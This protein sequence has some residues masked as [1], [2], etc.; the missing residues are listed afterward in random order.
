MSVSMRLSRGGSKKRP[1]YKI[2]VSNSRAPRDG[3]YLE[4]VGTYNPLLAKDDENRVRLVEDRVRYWIGVG[5]QPTDR[6][7]RM[8]DKAGIKERKPT[9]NP[10]AGEPG[11]KA[12]ERAE[13]K[14]EKA[15][16]A[17]EAAAAA[18]AAP[19]EEAPAAEAAAE[20][21]TEA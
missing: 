16:E 7:A 15:R 14:A 1:Y 4:Q 12:K 5:A 18:S 9:N 13:E 19:A 3:K 20:E 6:V 21:Q 2:V 17:A 11:K 10:Q 8:L